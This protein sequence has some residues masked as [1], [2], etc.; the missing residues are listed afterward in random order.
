MLSAKV[1]ARARPELA[2]DLEAVAVVVLD[3]LDVEDE[4]ELGHDVQAGPADL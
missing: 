2:L 4:A 3:T 1:A